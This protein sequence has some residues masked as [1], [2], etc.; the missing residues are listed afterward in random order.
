VRRRSRRLGRGSAGDPSDNF[1]GRE[2]LA[3]AIGSPLV[4]VLRARVTEEGA[5]AAGG[6]LA[7]R[8]DGVVDSVSFGIGF[9]AV[10]AAF[11]LPVE[12]P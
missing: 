9:S 10:G 8:S 4:S 1:S 11:E 2:Q 12:P 7:P 3:I 6:E 5:L